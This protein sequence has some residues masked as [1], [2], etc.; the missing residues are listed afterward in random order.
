MSEIPEEAI[1]ELRA[2]PSSASQFEEVFGVGAA[3]PYLQHENV[4]VDTL[5]G[6]A[7]GARDGIQATLDLTKDAGDWLND[8]LADLGSIRV[9]ED[10][11]NGVVDWVSGD[12]TS[13]LGGASGAKLPDFNRGAETL[14]GQLAHGLSQFITGWVTGGRLLRGVKATGAAAV[15]GKAFVQGATADFLAFGAHEKRLSNLVNT[16]FPELANPVTEYLAADDGDGVVEGRLKNVLEGGILGV[17]TEGTLHLARGMY[18]YLKAYKGAAK[19]NVEGRKAEAAGVMQ[20]AGKKFDTELKDSSDTLSPNQLD[21]MNAE[22]LELFPELPPTQKKV[23]VKDTLRSPEVEGL[24]ARLDIDAEEAEQ[25][26]RNLSARDVDDPFEN[27]KFKSYLTKESDLNEVYNELLTSAR[28]RAGDVF[29]ETQTWKEAERLA[30]EEG[31]DPWELL[32]SYKALAKSSQDASHMIVAAHATMNRLAHQV[33]DVSSKYM[34]GTLGEEAKITIQETTNLLNSIMHDDHLLG[35]NLGRALN[36]R[37]NTSHVSPGH[38]D[39]AD[40]KRIQNLSQEMKGNP[41]EF[42]KQVA[43]MRATKPR[44]VLRAL[45]SALRNRTWNIHNEYWINALLSHPKTHMVNITTASI[46]SVAKVAE[47]TLKDVYRGDLTAAKADLVGSWAALRLGLQDSMT[48]LR[49]LKS[50]GGGDAEALS[51]VAESSPLGRSMQT[52]MEQNNVLDPMH[53]IYE[54]QQ[55]AIYNGKGGV[56]DKV[57]DVVRTPSRMLG[58]EDEFLKQMNYRMNIYQQAYAEGMRKGMSKKELAEFAAE[59]LAKAFDATGEGIDDTALQ[60]A[61]EA[62]FTQDLA[63]RYD[64]DRSNIGLWMQT[65]LKD[66]PALRTLIPFIRVPTN[67]ARHT[68]QR[69]PLIGLIQH[70]MRK[71]ALSG[72]PAQKAE[73]WAKQTVGGLV[74]LAAWNLAEDG[75]LTGGGPKDPY[76]RRQWLDDGNIP[77]SFKTANGKQVQ[78]HRFD[79]RFSIFGI[80]ADAKYIRDEMQDQE[81]LD[82]VTASAAS[83]ARNLTSKTYLT[84][85]VD[86]IGAVESGDPTEVKRF[87]QRRLGSYVPN[88]ATGFTGDAEVKELRG[89]MDG[90]LARVPGVSSTVEARRNVLGEKMMKTEML[91]PDLISPIMTGKA[92]TDKLKH[93]LNALRHSFPPPPK[94]LQGTRID[95]TQYSNQR[96]GQTAYDRYQELTGEVTR[97]GKTLRTKLEDLIESPAYLAKDSLASPEF[98][99]LTSKRVLKI[100]KQL[101]LYRKS[102]MRQLKKEFPLLDRAMRTEQSNKRRVPVRGRNALEPLL[103]K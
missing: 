91:G 54:G 78:F 61:R 76:L 69:M 79:P 5:R 100:Q 45:R 44:K 64:N 99:H 98:D 24:S 16:E 36:V 51:H 26:A 97:G 18:S 10:A 55:H 67:L 14:P 22:Q 72:T 103:V 33:I 63:F 42:M 21:R 73:V 49:E 7:D 58:A 1:A 85:I 60:Y 37:K 52:F 34:D 101:R 87:F 8:N 2:D 25:L 93:E 3:T 75:K 68:I 11:A 86:V 84:G 66:M 94:K 80:L 15:T 50:V 77:Y 30:E 46:E 48:M 65:G 13:A 32:T 89:W 95:L 56:V 53:R 88:I 102:A 4:V 83:I 31:R 19:L 59:K 41:E 92:G 17:A 90:V 71:V 35:R 96:T 81:F 23:S 70:D 39:V 74:A 20:E 29:S 6:A 12:E 9:G 28:S 43:K 38:I 82:I 57:G 47:T 40:V 62:T 27:I